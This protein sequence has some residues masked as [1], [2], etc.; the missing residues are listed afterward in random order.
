MDFSVTTLASTTV[1]YIP[2]AT[3]YDLTRRHLGLAH[4]FW[5]DIITDGAIFR[6]WMLNLGRRTAHERIAHL[7][8]EMALR[9][10]A[11]GL[12]TSRAFEASLVSVDIGEAL[13]LSMVQ[14]NRV[15]QDFARDGLVTPKAAS[16]EV[17]D[18]TG[19]AQICD[20]DPVYLHLGH[21]V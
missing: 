6:I 18:F 17:L 2:H 7:L 13:G 10:E 5:R 20:F 1:G 11:V 16:V 19:L 9:L 8:C 4:A 14:V 3:L 21:N 15:L 12:A